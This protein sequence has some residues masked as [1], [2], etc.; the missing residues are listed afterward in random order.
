MR[1]KSYLS[2]LLILLGW[3]AGPLMPAAHGQFTGVLMQ[4]NDL[5]RTGQNLQETTLT[6]ANVTQKKFG[7]IFSYPVDGQIYAQP[8]YVPNVAIAGGTHNVLIVATENDTVYAFDADGLSPTVLWQVSFVNPGA[9]IAPAPCSTSGGCNV[10]PIVGVTATPA[11]DLTSKTIYVHAKTAVTSGSTTT[12]VHS[13]HALD[14]FTGQEK[15]GGPITITGSVPGTGTGSR[16][17][18]VTFD[19]IHDSARSGL[20]LANG[21]VYVA[22]GGSQHGWLF[23]YNATTLAPL[24]SSP[25]N[26]TP[27]GTLGSI[28]QS[29]NG[30]AVDSQGNLF[31]STGDGTFD[32]NTGGRDYGDTVMKLSPTL[33]VLDYF[34]PMDQSCRFTPAPNNDLDLG[35]SGPMILPTQGG[36]FP[37]EI[38]AS[39]KGGDPCDLFGSTYAVPIYLLNRDGL[40]GYNPAQ[41]QNIQTVAGTVMGYWGNPAFFQGPSATYIYYSGQ[42]N[43]S[44]GGDHLE[45]YTL[46]N[47]ALSTAPIALSTNLFP[48][49]STP[50]VSANGTSNGILWS[51]ERKDI[52]AA[53][54][55]NHTATLYA[56]DATNVATTLYYSGQQQSR[57]ATGCGNKMQQ[58]T[59][60]KGKV[61]VGTQ[62]ELDVF[63]LLP[64]SPTTPSPSITVPCFS[65]N[66]TVGTTSAAQTTKLTNLGPGNLVISA[67]SFQGLNGNQFGQTNTCGASLPYT[68]AAKATCNISV[69]FSPTVKGT[70]NGYLLINDN[71]IGGGMSLQVIGTGK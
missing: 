31:F 14:L 64:A 59:I 4:H 66:A 5:A 9:G 48:A 7:K 34:T 2:A 67:M 12:N 36:A 29:G 71:A 35:S 68:L 47:G 10:Y 26:T 44:G 23:A 16:R 62:N 42:T 40:G 22:L 52:L 41:D 8:L 20:V 17:G 61:Y 13:L 46:T 63:G 21:N 55:G 39:G 24:A 69:T 38:V 56:Y 65:F 70:L 58:P 54:P 6:P 18:V 33:Q 50:S 51:V 32:V 53:A 37:D 15:F 19:P 27:N 25:L 30:L 43:E 60:A 28:W 45:Q 57:D 3:A 11:I 1:M 49:S